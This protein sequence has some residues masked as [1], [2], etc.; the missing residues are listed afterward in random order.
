M[1][2]WGHDP[3]WTGVPALRELPARP[4]VLPRPGW[5]RLALSFVSR[6]V[7]LIIGR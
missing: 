4:L 7:A 2:R 5:G 1:Y 6:L 3:R